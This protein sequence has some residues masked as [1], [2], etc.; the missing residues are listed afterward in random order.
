MAELSDRFAE[1]MARMARTDA[2]LFRTLGEQNASVRELVDALTPTAADPC[3]ESAP[4]SAAAAL[5]PA[6]LLPL[7]DCS[8]PALKAR[9]PRAADAQAWAEQRLGPAPKKATWAVLVQTF[10]S[11]AWPVSA[12][13]APP[14]ATA[15]TVA[16]LD[17]RLEAMEQRLNQ[18]LSR[19]EELLARVLGSA[20]G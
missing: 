17:Q 15:L 11:G 9:F 10:Q 20:Q 19:L 1:L 3:P 18:R 4:Q 12:P 6:S 5:G 2:D 7:P 14:R 8:L 16:Q 13:K